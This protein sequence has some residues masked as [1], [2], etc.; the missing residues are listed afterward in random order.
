MRL[1]YECN[2]VAFIAEQAGGRAVAGLEPVL[3]VIPDKIHQRSAFITGS[4]SMVDEVVKSIIQ[5]D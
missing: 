5:L 3:D 2:P 1:L 4:A